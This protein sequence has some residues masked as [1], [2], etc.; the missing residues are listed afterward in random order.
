LSPTT[1][2]LYAGSYDISEWPYT[3]DLGIAAMDPYTGGELWYVQQKGGG[4]P[5]VSG[6]LVYTTADGVTISGIMNLPGQ[7]P[8]H[9]AE[10]YSSNI[11]NLLLDMFEHPPTI[12]RGIFELFFLSSR[13]PE[14]RDHVLG[15][16][17]RL[18]AREPSTFEYWL[19]AANEIQVG[20]QR[21]IQ[22][23]AGGRARGY[24]I[25]VRS[26][27]RRSLP[28]MI[29]AHARAHRYAVIADER[30]G[31]LYGREIAEGLTSRGREAHLL[32]F[33]PGEAS[34]T[35][36]EWARLTDTMLEAGFGR[37]SA[38]ALSAWRR[39]LQNSCTLDQF[40]DL[41][42]RDWLNVK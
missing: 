8:V 27:I 4:D 17:D 32:T 31:E 22:V 10:L 18:V 19:H 41:I 39:L 3:S 25:R 26:G 42:G 5:V 11:C 13:E 34:K 7:V 38:A 40:F 6:G 21:A 16:Y 1:G 14:F 33:P 29:P 37:D 12:L 9:S 23:Q 24:P 15:Y 20:D 2:Y 35:R 30:V 28:Q 36:E